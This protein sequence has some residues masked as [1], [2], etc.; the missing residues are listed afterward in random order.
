MNN[1][2]QADCLTYEKQQH[3]SLLNIEHALFSAKVSEYGG[4]LLSFKPKGKRELIWLSDSAVTDGTK[5][6]RGGAPICWPWFG[7]APSSSPEQP[8]HGFARTSRWQL[9]QLSETD[10][11]V[12]LVL[13]SPELEQAL[14]EQQLDLV[15]VYT[16]SDQA[17]IALETTN[18]G[19]NDYELSLA[20]HSYF[21]IEDITHTQ[22]PEL[23]G[24]EYFD[25]LSQSSAVLK[26]ALT[27]DAP[28]DR[29][30]HYEGSEL[31]IKTRRDSI[32]LA[33][34]GHDSVVVWNPWQDGAHAMTDFDD[35]GYRHML[36]VEAALT[37]NH[38]LKPGQTKSVSQRFYLI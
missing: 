23:Q 26:Q 25:K 15:L 21:D 3:F 37:R 5:A 12:K 28:V 8:Q 17:T 29:I 11:E 27:V 7:A 2:I 9:V 20:I 14:C 24:I 34:S 18:R 32:A 13:K 1:Q 36:C 33:H 19:I 4:Q 30:F 35:H 31:T 22:I 6:I 10:T 38:I 16:F